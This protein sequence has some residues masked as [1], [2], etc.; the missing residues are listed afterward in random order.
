[1]SQPFVVSSRD[2]A[3]AHFDVDD[4]T[5]VRDASTLGLPPG[6]WPRELLIEVQD[7]DGHHVSYQ[8]FNLTTD[9]AGTVVLSCTYTNI[10]GH[11]LE[12]VND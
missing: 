12:L 2:F 10:D 3:I 11:V 4:K 5:I 6:A 9:A 8:R 1:M 7:G